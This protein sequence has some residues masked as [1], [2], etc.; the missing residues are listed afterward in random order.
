MC[1]ERERKTINEAIVLN[2]LTRLDLPRGT[3]RDGN[4]RARS[5]K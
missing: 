4:L 5:M 1:K 3:R 2:C